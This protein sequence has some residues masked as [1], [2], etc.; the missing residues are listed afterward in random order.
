[1]KVGGKSVARND[2]LL[3]AAFQALPEDFA[4]MTNVDLFR[5]SLADPKLDIRLDLTNPRAPPKRCSFS[6][7]VV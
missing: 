3:L 7:S 2:V 5:A 1:M 6:M 4:G